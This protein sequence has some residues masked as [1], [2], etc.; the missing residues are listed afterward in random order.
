PGQ[1]LELAV[2]VVG[3]PVDVLGHGHGTVGRAGHQVIEDVAEAGDA[4]GAV[5]GEALLVVPDHDPDLGFH[6]GGHREAGAG[7][8][9]RG[10][11]AGDAARRTARAGAVAADAAVVGGV[12]GHAGHLEAGAD[13]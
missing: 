8:L 7:P 3:V 9:G 5:D 1:G 4:G 12:G 11:S 6:I 10:D 13:A 2:A